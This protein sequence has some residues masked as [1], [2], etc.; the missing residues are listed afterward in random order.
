MKIHHIILRDIFVSYKI[1]ICSICTSRIIH[2]PMAKPQERQHPPTYSASTHECCV[3]ETTIPNL[4]FDNH[5]TKIILI[6]QFV[7]E[8]TLKYLPFKKKKVRQVQ[9]RSTTY[10]RNHS[11]RSPNFKDFKY[12]FNHIITYNSIVNKEIT[13]NL[14]IDVTWKCKTK[15]Q[16]E[17]RI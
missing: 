11:Q 7:E 9:S 6:Y 17:C 8:N 15:I 14:V 16:Q 13:L 12:D 10:Y 1:T 4:Q 3:I 2:T 5:F